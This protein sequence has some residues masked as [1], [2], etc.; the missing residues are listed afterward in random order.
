MT[1]SR[2]YV[3][4][5]EK[6]RRELSSAMTSITYLPPPKKKKKKQKYV[7][8]DMV[9]IH[10][11]SGPTETLPHTT[12]R[13]FKALGLSADC[14]SY[15]SI[16]YR[17]WK[18]RTAQ[19][20]RTQPWVVPPTPTHFDESVDV[21]ELI[22]FH[23]TLKDNVMFDSTYNFQPIRSKCVAVERNVK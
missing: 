11:L 16:E 22:E 21:N 13:K 2:Q 14:I 15:L 17:Q 20:N 3:F 7:G 9:Y 1:M 18:G 6:E 12:I 10:P 8:D 23:R 5:K 19:N 4:P